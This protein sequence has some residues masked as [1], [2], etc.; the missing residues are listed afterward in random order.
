MAKIIKVTI[1]GTVIELDSDTPTFDKLVEV[2][3]KNQDYD[4][5][6]MLINC[7]DTKFDSATF[8]EALMDVIKNTISSVKLNETNYKKAIEALDNGK[9]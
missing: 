9:E 3:I 7:E 5:S 4:Y 8:K 6:N 1:N 2:V